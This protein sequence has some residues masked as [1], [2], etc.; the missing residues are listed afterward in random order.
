[1]SF[2]SYEIFWLNLWQYFDPSCKSLRKIIFTIVYIFFVKYKYNVE[3][4]ELHKVSHNIVAKLTNLI[5]IL[6]TIAQMFFKDL[7]TFDSI[8]ST[9]PVRC[10]KKNGPLAQ[11]FLDI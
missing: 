11:T 8:Y 7:K 1:M 9:K 5:V 4:I 6:D 3:T 10:I 2:F